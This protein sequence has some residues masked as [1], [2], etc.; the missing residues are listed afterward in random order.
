MRNP[1]R[2]RFALDGFTWTLIVV[3]LA[4]VVGIVVMNLIV[5]GS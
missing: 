5:A 3:I 1:S 2:P 4:L